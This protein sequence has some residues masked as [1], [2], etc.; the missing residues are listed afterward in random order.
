[1]TDLYWYHY[2]ASLANTNA[3]TRLYHQRE[4]VV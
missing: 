3:Q 1:M 4:T 2:S